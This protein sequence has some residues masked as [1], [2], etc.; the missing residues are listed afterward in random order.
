MEKFSLIQEAPQSKYVL[1]LSCHSMEMRFYLR[2]GFRKE[3]ENERSQK[4]KVR[5]RWASRGRS[6][7]QPA[8]CRVLET[9]RGEEMHKTRRGAGGSHRPRSV[10]EFGTHRAHRENQ[11][12]ELSNRAAGSSSRVQSSL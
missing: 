10:Q 8:S 9:V 12:R 3:T 2:R 11:Q 7:E 4:G 6:T 1:V 5:V